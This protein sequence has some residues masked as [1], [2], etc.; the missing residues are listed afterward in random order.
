MLRLLTIIAFTFG[1]L[2]S[3]GAAP[4]KP[5][6][7][8]GQPCGEAPDYTCV[9]EINGPG[10]GTINSLKLNLPASGSIAVSL[11]AS[12]ECPEAAAV[13]TVQ[14]VRDKSARPANVGGGTRISQ[15]RYD[16]S[17]TPISVTAYFPVKKGKTTFYARYE[18][19]G[20]VSAASGCI[21]RNGTM[22]YTYIPD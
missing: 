8:Q 22:G 16:S 12:L 5:E 18:N 10:V 7:G 13:L 6:M 17:G 4:A 9:S 14:I 3:A 2:A 20:G 11:M 15:N 1:A 19:F 21:I